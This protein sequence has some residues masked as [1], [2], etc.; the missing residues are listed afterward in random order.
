[1][2][3]VNKLLNVVAGCEIR[4]RL[5]C[6][7]ASIGYRGWIRKALVHNPVTRL[8]RNRCQARNYFRPP[9]LASAIEAAATVAPTRALPERAPWFSRAAFSFSPIRADL[10]TQT[11]ESWIE[12]K[13]M[14]TPHH[15][16]NMRAASALNRL[17]GGWT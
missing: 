6:G 10:R 8:L 1:M 7:A 11:S 12:D 3:P 4:G 14:A 13:V 2:A 17:R 5:R 9:R 16:L 15:D